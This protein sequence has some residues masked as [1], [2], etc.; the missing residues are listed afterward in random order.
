MKTPNYI[1][2]FIFS[3]GC[4]NNYKINYKFNNHDSS[5]FKKKYNLFLDYYLQIITLIKTFNVMNLNNSPY[6][7]YV[8]VTWTI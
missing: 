1:L 5:S 6:F 3:A 8:F 2:I 7:I 4:F